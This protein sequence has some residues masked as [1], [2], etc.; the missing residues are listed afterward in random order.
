MILNIHGYQGSSKNTMF[1]ILE[2]LFPDQVLVSPQLN[3]DE[4]SPLE[5]IKTLETKVSLRAE[6]K[7]SGD[8]DHS[9]ELKLIVGT[10]LGGF[11]A[12]SLW[13]KFKTVPTILFNPAF[14]PWTI[15]PIVERYSSKAEEYKCIH[16]EARRNPGSIDNLHIILGNHDEVLGNVS[17]TIIFSLVEFCQREETSFDGDNIEKGL[18]KPINIRKIEC[19]HSAAGDHI[20]IAQIKETIKAFANNGFSNSRAVRSKK[21]CYFGD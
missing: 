16:D 2:E 9:D 18:W 8:S 1:Q 12:A 7:E 21:G 20:A 13:A 5:I 6:A 14:T 4:A 11:F 3:Y 15:Q 10:S 19:G 17:D